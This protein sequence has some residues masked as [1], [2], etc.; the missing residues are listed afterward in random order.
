MTIGRFPPLITP[1]VARSILEGERRV[2]LDLGISQTSIEDQNGGVLLPD[3]SLIGFEELERVAGRGEAVYFPREGR[4]KMV[5]VSDDHF[6]KLVPTMGAPTLEIDGIRMHRTKGITPEADA[7]SKVESLR[8]DGGNVLDTCTGLGYTAI[9]SAKRGASLVVSIELKYQV[10]MMAKINPWSRRLFEDP[11]IHLMIGD[12]TILLQALPPEFFHYI[13][14][15]PPRIAHAGQLYSLDF[16]KSLFRV[17]KA[18]GRLFHYT[19]EPGKRFRKLDIRKGV[20]ERLRSAGFKRVVYQR[21]LMGVLCEK[22]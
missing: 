19:G 10:L 20:M 21:D 12:S 17:L 6:Y 13:I 16:Y 18:G 7:E 22:I 2:S 5:A 14:H 1:L 3:G 9:A 8:I 11:R 15:D 4:L